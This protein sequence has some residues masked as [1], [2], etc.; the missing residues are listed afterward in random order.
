M[1]EE[2][3]TRFQLQVL[4]MSKAGK[5]PA[6]NAAIDASKGTVCLFLDDDIVASPELVAE[7]LAANRAN[8]N[9][10]G[11]GKL[12]QEPPAAR[13][14]YAQAFATAWN[15]HYDELSDKPPRWTDCY[16]G[17]LS[18]PRSA[19]IE[20]GGFATDLPAA[21]D[22]EL[23][24]R[25]CGVGCVPGY[26]PRAR[27][28]HDDQKRRDRILEDRRR[29]AS[30]YFEVA[31]RH[32]GALADMLGRFRAEG[33]R[34]VGLRRL[35]I[36]LRVPPTALTSLGGLLPGSGRKMVWFH[37]VTK[38]EFWGAIRR[39]LSRRQ[40]ASITAGGPDAYEKLTA[41]PSPQ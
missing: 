28:V 36:A 13:D 2:L 34:W 37:F 7:H 18:A 4:R 40:W 14:W 9:L 11:I 32:P 10:I 35:L 21:L 22:I 26:L 12:I 1:V 33:D 25:L 17:N 24:Y 6:L 38:L 30:A 39:N 15:E 27:G 20:I 19:L 3:S 8:A 5:S 41:A 31:D 16:G 29:Y 23:G